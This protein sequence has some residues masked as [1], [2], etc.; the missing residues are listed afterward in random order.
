MVHY[1]FKHLELN[2][3]QQIYAK[4]TLKWMCFFTFISRDKT[5]K[6]T[7]RCKFHNKHHLIITIQSILNYLQFGGIRNTSSLIT[8]FKHSLQSL[9]PEIPLWLKLVHWNI[10][11]AKSRTEQLSIMLYCNIYVLIF[12]GSA[13]KKLVYSAFKLSA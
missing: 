13:A 9:P 6:D 1:H 7:Q 3:K 11:L 10:S 2:C 4:P 8:H 5:L 12:S